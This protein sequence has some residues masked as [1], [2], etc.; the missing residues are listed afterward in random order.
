MIQMTEYIFEMGDALY[1]EETGEAI[2]QPK[3]V[4]ELIRCRD[5]KHRSKSGLCNMWSVFGTVTT[6]DEMYCSYG[7]RK[8]MYQDEPERKKSTWTKDASCPFCGFKPWYERDI[9]TLSFCPN[10]GADMRAGE[11]DDKTGSD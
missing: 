11:A 7:E 5:C 4:G 1:N 3:V 10:C 6:D 2:F 8:V 9:H